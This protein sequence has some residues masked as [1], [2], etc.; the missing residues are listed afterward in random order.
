M[1]ISEHLFSEQL[2]FLVHFLSLK[3]IPGFSPAGGKTFVILQASRAGRGPREATARRGNTAPFPIPLFNCSF[4]FLAFPVQLPQH[5]D[6][7][8]FLHCPSLPHQLSSHFGVWS[9]CRQSNSQR[10]RDTG[11]KTEKCSRRGSQGL[12]DP[13]PQGLALGPLHA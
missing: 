3:N 4:S 12:P 1:C 6:T 2:L 5:S 13:K 11:N 9:L 10:E 8:Q 7:Q